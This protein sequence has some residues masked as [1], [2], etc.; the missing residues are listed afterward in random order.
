[1]DMKSLSKNIRN[2]IYLKAFRF[3]INKRCDF[4]CSALKSA[5]ID[6]NIYGGFALNDNSI[7]F[8]FPEFND[9]KYTRDT[10]L[11]CSFWYNLDNERMKRTTVLYLCYLETL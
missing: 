7:P 3:I 1:M 9:K 4:I 8:L 11:N 10:N 6:Y 2:A 5:C